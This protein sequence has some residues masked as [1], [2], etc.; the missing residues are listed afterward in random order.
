[1]ELKNKKIPFV[2]AAIL[3]E[4]HHKR[5]KGAV[6]NIRNAFWGGVGLILFLVF[7]YLG[8]FHSSDDH[9]EVS[10]LPLIGAFMA[11]IGLT[12]SMTAR[13]K[14]LAD[15]LAG[16]KLTS[17]MKYY[18]YQ[19]I[20]R[21]LG[22]ILPK[23]LADFVGRTI[24]LRSCNVSVTCSLSSTVLDR[25]FDIFLTLIFFLTVLPFWLKLVPIYVCILSMV[26]VSLLTLLFLIMKGRVFLGILI[27]A[28]NFFINLLSKIPW[29]KKKI[30]TSLE[31]DLNKDNIALKAYLFSLSKYCFNVVRLICFSETLGGGIS[32]G[33]IL[34]SAPLGQIAYLISI[35]PGGLG[36]FEA[37]W[38]AI[39]INS[40]INNSLAAQF[41]SFQRIFSFLFLCVLS[42][43][44]YL[45]SRSSQR[46]VV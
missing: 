8:F 19:T 25:L 5:V 3:P 30:N 10:V 26:C 31:I 45:I 9:I 29:L 23:D 33:I 32:P 37:G 46:N 28:L 1:M 35:T 38:F 22:H 43:I 17:W 6:Y 39:L 15:S 21:V 20:N 41:V 44:S 36:I 4:E 12:I 7:V 18:Y 34:V 27:K 42:L 2:S 40:G 11:T 13:W 24:C 16:R 14:T